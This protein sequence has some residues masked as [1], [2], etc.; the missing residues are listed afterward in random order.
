MEKKD[1]ATVHNLLARYLA[2]FDICPKYTEEEVDHWL[3]HKE[4]PHGERVVWTYVVENSEGKVT[5]FFSFYSLESSVINHPKHE[6]IR[7]AYLFYYASETALQEGEP[8]TVKA[9]LK[10]RLNEL[11][12]DALILAKKVRPIESR[13]LHV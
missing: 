2:K 7:A 8:D 1:V 13:E 10:A 11:M 3:L 12:H 6:K 4:S 9:A 5:D